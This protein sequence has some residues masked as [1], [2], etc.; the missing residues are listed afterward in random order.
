MEVIAVKR[1]LRLVLVLCC[2]LL[3]CCARAQYNSDDV[4]R[5]WDTLKLTAE[6]KSKMVSVAEDTEA[7]K[8]AYFDRTRQSH[9]GMSATDLEALR[10]KQAA[11]WQQLDSDDTGQ[12]NTVLTPTQQQS[13]RDLL[14]PKKSWYVSGYI[15]GDQKGLSHYSVSLDSQPRSQYFTY[16]IHREE[17]RLSSLDYWG[18]PVLNTMHPVLSADVPEAVKPVPDDYGFD[19]THLALTFARKAAKPGYYQFQL[20][21]P[22]GAT[23]LNTNQPAKMR[24]ATA[25]SYQGIYLTPQPDAEPALAP[26]QRFIGSPWS[27]V[28][29]SDTAYKDVKTSKPIKWKHMNTKIL[30][31]RKVEPL[32]SGNRLTFDLEGHSGQISLVTNATATT[33]PCLA[34]LLTEPNVR[35]LKAGYEGKS[36]WCYGGAG[37]QCISSDSNVAISMGGRADLPMRIRHIERVYKPYQEL[38]IG[39]ATFIGGERQSAFVTDNP[40]IVILDPPAKGLELSGFM[41]VSKPDAKGI[42]A[43]FPEEVSNP[44]AYCLGLMNI[45]ADK[46]DFEREYSLQSPLVIGKKWSAKMRK[47]VLEGE[48]VKGMTRE[49]V[50]WVMGWPSIYGTKQEMLKLNDWTYDNIP[51][52]GHIYFRNGVVSSGISRV[53]PFSRRL[54]R[55]VCLACLMK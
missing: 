51:S 34:P 55:Q 28:D 50:A 53:S 46:W 2:V 49:M 42:D 20:T 40:L 1:S 36:V 52:D 26:G 35:A 41:S 21:A 3:S 43:A 22:L 16:I 29:V 6:Q 24:D 17:I 12:V 15:F 8:S 11:E 33:L 45:F 7:K 4:I 38:A 19:H 31:L 13:L 14:S 27:E 54:P 25:R 9:R 47:A 18:K 23:D 39:A 44:R 30:V 10:K 32:G 48:V 37:G 5:H